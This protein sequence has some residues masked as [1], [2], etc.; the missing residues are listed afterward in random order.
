MVYL[1]LLSSNGPSY[2][3]GPKKLIFA[4][5][6]GLCILQ[7]CSS[8]LSNLPTFTLSQI[9]LNR[10]DKTDVWLFFF[11]SLSLS[12][13]SILIFHVWTH[14]WQVKMC[15]FCKKAYLV[16]TLEMVKTRRMI[17][18]I[19]SRDI[20]VTLHPMDGTLSKPVGGVPAIYCAWRAHVLARII[21]QVS[22]MSVFIYWIRTFKL[23]TFL[24]W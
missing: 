7:A 12:H 24:Y 9:C 5:N 17:R 6:E 18:K 11:L 23:Y 2:S 13:I 16:C 4:F 1:I 15:S 21:Q 20:C 3:I 14:L 10:Q 19:K 22:L 8:I